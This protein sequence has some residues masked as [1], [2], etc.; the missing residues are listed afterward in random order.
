[1]NIAAVIS[2]HDNKFHD[3]L[4]PWQMM[5]C[6]YVAFVW[7]ALTVLSIVASYTGAQGDLNKGILNC[8]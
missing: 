5:S 8:L 4:L 2:C 1:M 7:T 3:K 6:M